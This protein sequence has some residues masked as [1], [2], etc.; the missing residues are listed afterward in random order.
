[1]A[2]DSAGDVF[3]VTAV[4]GIAG[5]TA[6]FGVVYRVS[7]TGQQTVLHTF[8]GGADGGL[9]NGVIRDAAGNLFGATFLGGKWGAGVVFKLDPSGAQTISHDF[10]GGAD[11]GNP[12]GS[13]VQDPS[14][15]L[16]GDTVY[17]GTAGL[18]VVYRIDPSGDETVLYSFPGG[19]E[20]ALPQAGLTLASASL[21]GTTAGGGGPVD[22]G[23]A[24][25]VFKLDAAGTYTVLST[26][27]GGLEGGDPQLPVVLDA[28]GNIYGTLQKNWNST[29]GYSLTSSCGLLY[30]LNSADRRVGG[31]PSDG[32]G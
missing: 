2:V 16:Y 28:A 11:G 22:E 12:R 31:G 13:L 14:G 32:P 30:R 5:G 29:C 17:G 26:F 3:G 10:T 4:G 8:T 21:Y 1:V 19:P 25:L 6:G 7:A 27:A 24:G 23:G 20:G 9:P 15:N 18:G